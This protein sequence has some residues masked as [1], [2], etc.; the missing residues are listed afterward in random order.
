[1][2]CA[3]EDVLVNVQ[4][5][6]APAA[7]HDGRNPTTGGSSSVHPSAT[8]AA[9]IALPSHENR[10]SNDKFA[11]RDQALRI[12]I[13]RGVVIVARDDV[14]EFTRSASTLLN[15]FCGDAVRYA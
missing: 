6:P 5:P 11:H 8:A 13:P 2:P 10:A 4:V 1:M 3:S 9:G 15:L 14:R 12:Q 7:V